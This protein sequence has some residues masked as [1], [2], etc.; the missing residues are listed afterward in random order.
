MT[1]TFDLWPWTFAVY[2]LW[3]DETLYQ[4][5]AQSSNPWRSYC[6][7]N[8][9]TSVTGCARL[10]L[11]KFELW[12]FIRARII[13]FFDADTLCHALTRWPWKFV[14]HQASCM[15]SKSVRNLNEIGQ[16]PAELWIILRIFA[17]VMS[18]CDHNLWPLDLELLQHFYCHA[19]K[20]CTKFERNRLIHGWVIYDLACFRCAILRDGAGHVYRT[21][22][23]D[24]WTQ[25]HQTGRGHRAIIST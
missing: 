3:R 17:H 7:F 11:T 22:L 8:I 5:W 2:G 23:R 6:D 10:I 21:V 15:R 13:A 18:R 16:F 19:F 9:W 1:L 24:A 14:V 20:L 4:I 25:L 12:Q